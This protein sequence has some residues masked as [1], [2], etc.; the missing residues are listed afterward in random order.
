MPVLYY[1]Q[2]TTDFSSLIERKIDKR[3]F[4]QSTEIRG[5]R[6]L[7]FYSPSEL[8]LDILRQFSL[9]MSIHLIFGSFVMAFTA[10]VRIMTRGGCSSTNCEI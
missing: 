5:T 10:H 2:Y 3:F 1:R 8:S 4:L 9:F 7:E 6:L